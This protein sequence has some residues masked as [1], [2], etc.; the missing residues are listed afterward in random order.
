MVWQ[1]DVDLVVPL[2]Q[3]GDDVR[4]APG[5]AAL[6]RQVPSG[7][8]RLHVSVTDGPR[9][10]VGGVLNLETVAETQRQLGDRLARRD[11][12]RTLTLGGDCCSDLA[13]VRHL[14]ARYPGMACYWV[15]AHPD[16]NTPQSSPSGRAHGMVLRALLG[17]GHARLTGAGAALSARDVTLVGTRA[18]DPAEEE[19]VRAHGVAVAGPE[20]VEADP[21]GVALRRTA[22]SPAYV[23]L[24]VDVCD[25]AEVP[26]VA[27]PEPGGPS[28]EAV[29]RV[30]AALARH[31]EVVGI[32]VCEYAPVIE[33]D[34]KRLNVLLS[35]LGLCE[36]V[37]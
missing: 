32:G 8:S 22:G 9:R 31:H 17:Q 28:V 1:R 37:F 24:D 18:F 2:W 34:S 16:L 5:A 12:A 33:H 25:P 21:D 27:C 36:P 19:F 14:A 10:V 4:V 3:G 20:A 11:P 29:A 23:H 30:L 7:G 6:A 15:D 35:A 26:A 13:A